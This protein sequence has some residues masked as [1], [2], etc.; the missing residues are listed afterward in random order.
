MITIFEIIVFWIIGFFIGY[1]VGKIKKVGK[2]DKS[3]KL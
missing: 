3:K 2:N 1:C